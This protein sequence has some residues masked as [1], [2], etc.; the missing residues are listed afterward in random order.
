MSKVYV[1]KAVA[2]GASAQVIN[3]PTLMPTLVP[4][5]TPHLAATPDDAFASAALVPGAE[6][7]ALDP[8][9]D[10]MYS[11][12]E[13]HWEAVPDLVGERKAA[14]WLRENYPD[15]ATAGGARNAW[16]FGKLLAA[17]SPS[18]PS[19]DADTGVVIPTRNA[20]LRIGTDG[21][22]TA[23]AHERAAGMRY[24][25]DAGAPGVRIG[26]EYTPS[27]VPADS[28]F[29]KFLAHAQTDHDVLDFIQ[30]QA[31]LT[32]M[33]GQPQ[34]AAWWY[35]AKGSGKSTMA[36]IIKR[37]HH[38]AVALD[39]KNLDGFKLEKIIGASLV[40]CT[41]VERGRWNEGIFKQLTGGD[42]VQIDRKG[43]PVIS[44][45]SDAKWII[46]SNLDP[47]ITDPTGAVH[48]RIAP[49][50]WARTVASEQRNNRLVD[51]IMKNE[52]HIVLDWL[53]TGVQRIVREHQG[54]FRPESKWPAAVRRWS[55]EIRG[56]SN[57]VANWIDS[58][59]IGISA[60]ALHNRRDIFQAFEEWATSH[61]EHEVISE[62]V[63]WRAFWSTSECAS[64]KEPERHEAGQTAKGKRT[65]VPLHRIALGDDRREGDAPLDTIP[66]IHGDAGLS[67]I[68]GVP[69][70]E[71]A[72]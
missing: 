6:R 60:A 35:G 63:F 29:G 53:L 36:S 58:E 54:Q 9:E 47:W 25:V 57:P 62:P 59:R 42:E 12:S 34:I 7:Y 8:D 31:A 14:L 10:V 50:R 48:R 44:Y 45:T 61:G 18:V 17:S 38:R 41:E 46:C 43:R 2:Q 32:L 11:W 13:T 4:A 26:A 16:A 71:K 68:F 56:A 40:V 67:D 24:L 1:S 30:E 23:E 65:M 64:A 37:F 19:V 27:L 20:Y 70:S 55:R 21:R 51:D 22:I 5:I 3:H 69:T 15:K 72:L 49:V 52:A 66:V 33:P 39:M 28:K